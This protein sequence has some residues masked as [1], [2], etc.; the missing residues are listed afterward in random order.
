MSRRRGITI[1][2]V[3]AVSALVPGAA[4]LRLG[5]LTGGVAYLGSAAL[6]TGVQVAAPI[7]DASAAQAAL[8]S[9]TAFALGWVLSA[10]AARSAARLVA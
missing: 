5:S 4:H 2:L 3:I 1:L 7:V 9:G 10:L 8:I 6:L